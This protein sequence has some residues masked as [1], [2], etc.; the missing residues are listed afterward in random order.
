MGFLS[1]FFR[2]GAASG[3]EPAAAMSNPAVPAGEPQPA[4]PQPVARVTVGTCSSCG[5]DLRMKAHAIKPVV[6]LT[7]KCGKG[8]EIHVAAEILESP[9]VIAAARADR[10]A[11]EDPPEVKLLIAS[12]AR[13]LE[14]YRAQPAGFSRSSGGEAL[15]EIREIGE[16]LHRAGGFDLMVRAHDEFRRICNVPGAPR[17]LEMMWSGIGEWMG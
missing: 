6:R 7:C 10:P 3:N 15:R 2:G 14:L 9:A 16:S 13:L 4:L 12:A 11:Y 8:S 1:R 5:H 17:N